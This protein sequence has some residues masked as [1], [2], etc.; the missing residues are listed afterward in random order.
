LGV[1]KP[2]HLIFDHCLKDIQYIYDV[3]KNPEPTAVLERLDSAL[4]LFRL[5]YKGQ[6][7]FHYFAANMEITGV[8]TLVFEQYMK[9]KESN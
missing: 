8:I 9:A 5:K 1:S 2:H 3:I 7:L 6:S 4:P